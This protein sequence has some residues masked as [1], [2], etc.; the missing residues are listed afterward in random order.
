MA[1]DPFSLALGGL[2]VWSGI[3]QAGLIK[4]QGKINRELAEINAAYAEADA[5]EAEKFG[6]TQASRYQSTIDQTIGAQR[7]AFAA[8]GIDVSSESARD[9]QQE[10]KLTGFLNK[11]DIINHARA[12]A[13]GIK[14]QA[15]N[16]RLQ[17]VLGELQSSLDASGAQSRALFAGIATGASGWRKGT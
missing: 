2:Q 6:Y 10:S 1:A 3:Q 4:E 16:I 12:N 15:G 14:M 8:D 17:G 9:L 11:L 13:L 7:I 5:D